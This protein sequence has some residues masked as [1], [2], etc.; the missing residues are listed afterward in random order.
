MLIEIKKSE[1]FIK[2]IRAYGNS[3]NIYLPK[4]L[5]GQNVTAFLLRNKNIILDNEETLIIDMLEAVNRTIKKRSTGAHVIVPLKWVDGTA[6]IF[7]N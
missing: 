4:D 1:Y 5:I 7:K 2:N 6:I 3:G